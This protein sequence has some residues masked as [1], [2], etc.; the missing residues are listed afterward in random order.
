MAEKSCLG[1]IS[2]INSAEKFA[3]EHQYSSF[4]LFTKNTEE[5]EKIREKLILD[6]AFQVYDRQQN[7]RISNALSKLMVFYHTRENEKFISI[8]TAVT[9]IKS[10][11]D[12]LSI[13]ELS[14][15]RNI[16]LDDKYV[17]N[18]NEK[19]NVNQP[20]QSIQVPVSKHPEIIETKIEQSDYMLIAYAKELDQIIY[21]E[22]NIHPKETRALTINLIKNAWAKA[23][24][25]RYLIPA[26]PDKP[27]LFSRIA[28]TFP[29]S[30]YI[31]D[32]ELTEE[33][34]NVLIYYFRHVYKIDK[35]GSLYKMN[36]DPFFA[37]ALVQIGMRYYNEDYWPDVSR[38]LGI[39]LDSNE[40]G[41]LRQSFMSLLDRY[42]KIH[43][44]NDNSIWNI[45][46]HGFVSDYY[47]PKFMSMLYRYYRIDLNRNL[48]NNTEKMLSKLLSRISENKNLQFVVQTKYA[49]QKNPK[50]SAEI[51]AELLY[52]LDIGF[53]DND[54][55]EP[56][57]R[58]HRLLNQ[59]MQSDDTF[60]IALQKDERSRTNFQKRFTKPYLQY[61]SNDDKMFLV[62]PPQMIDNDE[63]ETL[64]WRINTNHEK[65]QRTVKIFE[66]GVTGAETDQL[67]I[68]LPDF[69]WFDEFKMYVIDPV[70]GKLFTEVF[71]IPAESARFIDSS[72]RSRNPNHF[73]NGDLTVII[74]KGYKVQSN[75]LSD[76]IHLHTHDIAYLNCETGD[77]VHISDGN[78]YIAGQNFIEGLTR[79]LFNCDV[80]TEINGKRVP[81]YADLPK[82]RFKAKPEMV[83]GMA[84]YVN[85]KRLSNVRDHLP[86]AIDLG[87]GTEENGYEIWLKDYIPNQAGKY[88]IIFDFSGALHRRKY[89]D[90]VYL[91]QLSVKFYYHPYIFQKKGS[92]SLSC[93]NLQITPLL[94]DVQLN[95]NGDAFIFPIDRE[96]L[97]LSFSAKSGTDEILFSIKVPCLRYSFGNDIWNTDTTELIFK[98]DLPHEILF[99]FP[100]DELTV[101]LM[102]EDMELSSEIL[103]KKNDGFFHYATNAVRNYSTGD[104]I[105][106]E[107]YLNSPEIQKNYSSKK[108]FMRVLFRSYIRNKKI[109]VDFDAGTLNGFID[110]VG[111]ANYSLDIYCNKTKIA[112]DIPL[113]DGNFS[114]T[115]NISNGIYKFDVYEI[116]E[117]EFGLGEERIS[118]ESFENYFFDIHN[119]NGKSVKIKYLLIKKFGKPKYYDF[120]SSL[121]IS[122]LDKAK[123]EGENCYYGYLERLNVLVRIIFPDLNKL[124]FAYITY[125][126]ESDK[127][128]V[129]LIYE[130]NTKALLLEKVDNDDKYRR[131]YVLLNCADS[132][133]NALPKRYDEYK[134]IFK[135][136]VE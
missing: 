42:G 122:D 114:L 3:R 96:H 81:L 74:K 75:A 67:E 46:L 123:K 129:D 61:N 22:Y 68:E 21:N 41:K 101:S 95:D 2:S 28:Q 135:I 48:E 107:L 108:R 132:N 38:E 8:D 113:I 90:F 121:I 111:N 5:A 131:D 12:V 88:N 105:H 94:S 9:E 71:C 1:Y 78:H 10:V 128:F 45:M 136:S 53:H 29:N 34:Y 25:Q 40:Q 30:I 35:K 82:I 56:T 69:Q 115:Q 52:L 32:I 59:W 11:T 104:Y 80:Y 70:S 23:Y 100:D 112:E 93:P 127:K 83:E 72:G 7:K 31:G 120:N 99:D 37:V 119:L 14:Q 60:Q 118:I 103:V 116:K 66:Q 6:S 89:Y 27:L 57:T 134:T 47:A 126:N 86:A 13:D 65:M 49:V 50:R 19:E 43:L 20:E 17:N 102:N 15:Q 55:R 58:L 125:W 133:W 84:I 54:F 51:I 117:D 87:T 33:E 63:Q 39:Q 24:N 97:D 79:S 18:E 26:K 16:N 98:E 92:V 91:P 130:K 64:E 4:T 106:A 44:E 76:V 73:P 109:T 110:I 85:G 36:Q 77:I 124:D 62:I